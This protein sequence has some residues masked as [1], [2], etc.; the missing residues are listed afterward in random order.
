MFSELIN[1]LCWNAA[2]VI[3]L[4]QIYVTFCFVFAFYDFFVA[5]L[6]TS[7]FCHIKLK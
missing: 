2:V 5:C 1:E 3:N 6:K 4:R 7:C